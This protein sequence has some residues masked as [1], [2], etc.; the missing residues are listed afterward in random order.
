[1]ISLDNDDNSRT[2]EE[3]ELSSNLPPKFSIEMPL[4]QTPEKT[5]TVNL[6]FEA[7]LF[8]VG[9]RDEYRTNLKA[10]TY[11][12]LRCIN[13]RERMHELM[14]QYANQVPESIPKYYGKLAIALQ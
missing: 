12:Q 1:M 8:K 4:V 5:I 10:G 13:A 2:T 14:L 9:D 6:D 3:K 11:I 7:A